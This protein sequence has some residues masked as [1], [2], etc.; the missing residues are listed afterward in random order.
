MVDATY[1][2]ELDAVSITY[3][4]RTVIVDADELNDLS[5]LISKCIS[6]R[7]MYIRRLHEG[8]H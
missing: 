6:D 3:N 2:P 4:H 5:K 8:Y 7:Y 1:L